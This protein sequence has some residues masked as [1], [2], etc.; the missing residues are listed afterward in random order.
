[1]KIGNLSHNIFIAFILSLFF[2][3]AARDLNGFY[4]NQYIIILYIAI[5]LCFARYKYVVYSTAVILPLLM[6]VN[7]F[8]IFVPLLFLFI[9]SKKI[10]KRQVIY[11]LVLILFEFVLE[12]FFSS[13]K[14]YDLS[15]YSLYVLIFSFLLFDENEGYDYGEVIKYFIVSTAFVSLII[16]LYSIQTYGII[17]ILSGAIRIGDVNSELAMRVGMI[18]DID[19]TSTHFSVNPNTLA[20]FSISSISLLLVGKDKLKVN[21]I[22]YILSFASLLVAGAL[23]VSRTWMLCL[24]LLFALYFQKKIRDNIAFL[25][26]ASFIVIIV[27]FIFRDSIIAELFYSRMDNGNLATGG[28]RTEIF[29]KY[30]NF[31]FDHPIHLL[32]GCSV[33]NYKEVAHIVNSVHC[34][35]Q[36]ILVCYGCI[37]VLIFLVMAYQFFKRFYCYK[38]RKPFVYLLPF[39]I[40]FLFDQSIQF[41]NPH[42]LM[43]PFIFAGYSLRLSKTSLV[44]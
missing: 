40:I 7:Q 31:L 5:Y 9:K 44:R 30:M 28:G 16:V 22:V 3:L 10:N 25:L 23:T 8:T 11:P 27:L 42:Y 41:L 14:L 43:L 4:I 34:G 15:L 21:R 39:I 2:I 36:Q 6:G 37:G 24:V 1:M 29:S 19:E 13:C 35:L 32:L 38:G 17:S 18:S 20:Y 26:L 33:M 12:V